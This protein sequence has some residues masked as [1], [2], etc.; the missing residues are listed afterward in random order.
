VLDLP[1]NS[2]IA[3][4]PTDTAFQ[5]T[6]Q[7]EAGLALIPQGVANQIYAIP[8][9]TPG[10]AAR[11]SFFAL[12]PETERVLIGRTDLRANPYM[13]SLIQNLVSIQEVNGVGFLV[14]DQGT[15]LYHPQAEQIM[16]SYNGQ[17]SDQPVFFDETASRRTPPFGSS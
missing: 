5:L 7:E 16:T 4:Y 15:I 13:R 3:S 14:D 1:S 12:I 2:I 11:I 6:Q 9:V 10:E 17:R 8:P